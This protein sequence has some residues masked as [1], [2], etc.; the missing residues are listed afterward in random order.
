MVPQT[1]STRMVRASIRVRW[2][3]GS[4]PGGSWEVTMV[5]WELLLQPAAVHALSSNAWVEYTP[6]AG[7]H[8]HTHCVRLM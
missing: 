4:G 8:T 5:T 6:R 3:G 1:H 2:G 7:T